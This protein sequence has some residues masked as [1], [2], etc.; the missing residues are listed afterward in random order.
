[1]ANQFIGLQMRVV[2]RDPPGYRLVGTVRDVE[3]GSS[4]SLTN[5]YI[6]A[7]QEH[8]PLMRINALNIADLSELPRDQ[9]QQPLAPPDYDTPTPTQ[10]PGYVAQDMSPTE[11]NFVDP[12][13][14][15]M[16]RRPGSGPPP[17]SAPHK[18]PAKPLKP[19]M[20][21]PAISV[22]NPSKGDLGRLFKSINISK[23][24]DAE[25]VPTTP[26]ATPQKRKA[27][28]RNS[29]QSKPT[30]HDDDGVAAAPGS[31]GKGWRQTPMLQST[32]SFQ[33]FKAL[34]K[35]G[36]TPKV[37]PDNGWASED[38]TEEMPEFDF[39]NNLAKFDKRTLFD[40]MRKEDVV[41]E[42]DRLV[43]HNRN[44]KPGTAGG[45]NLHYTENVLD[46]PSSTHNADY[47]NSEAE[48]GGVHQ[49]EVLSGREQK[50][51]QSTKRADSKSGPS[52]RSQSRKASAAMG[53]Q[54]L[55]RVNSSVRQSLPSR[56]SSPR[57][58]YRSADVQP[59]QIQQPG[60]YLV[61]SNRRVEAISTLQMLNLE[62]IAANEVG[63]PETLMAENAGR[64]IA[65][66]AVQALSDPALKVRYEMAG[67]ALAQ[68]SDA[69]PP[70][71]STVVILAGN[72]KS[73]IRAL[74]AG[75]HLRNKGYDIMV[76]LVGIERERDLLEELR[77][78]IQL[79][80]SFGG[81]VLKK[82]DFFEQLRKTT[83]AGAA[84]TSA[85]SSGAGR[86]AVSLIIDALLGL[87]MSFEELRIGDQATVYELME[88]ANRNE[89]FV[90]AIDVPSGIDPS[91]GKVAIIDGSQL[92]VKPRYVVAVGAPKRGLVEAV[93]PPDDEDPLSA[94]GGI[95][96]DEEWRLYIVDM[97]LGHTVWRKA[98]T[99]VR[100]GI[101]FDGKWVLGM[102][103]R[104]IQEETDDY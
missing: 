45:K 34:K 33:P 103:Y 27:R 26:E 91:T 8:V 62:N 66:V 15:S 13:I 14:L 32:S 81:K 78:Q 86:V 25:N 51:G 101:D 104:G 100:K 65:E 60:L 70:N 1:M 95:A 102:K 19:D 90:L 72:N 12:A 54:P 89:A 87:T 5:V 94:N 4:L 17:A 74:V 2:L 76:C 73:S 20:P 36:K 22:E 83:P 63:L 42:A 10:P 55:S 82:N 64:G 68:A 18:V 7:T 39:E 69:S 88:W 9:P 43:S 46:L 30:E 16:G 48:V 29:R 58:G 57:S 52:R 23:A 56:R 84:V 61:P 77:R 11:S 99:K 44:P 92:F 21:Y 40:Q 37:L 97:G 80:R 53:G 6:V 50:S 98:G 93:T 96:Q 38:V 59:P 79:Y 3:A 47:W 24:A 31:H 28:N 35:N 75:R 41:D 49:N 67:A 71:N 85:G